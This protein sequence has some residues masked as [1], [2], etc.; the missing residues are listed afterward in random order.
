MKDEREV[1]AA[2]VRE[3]F[4]R[5]EA[6][7]RRRDEV[8]NEALAVRLSLREAV[9]AQAEAAAAYTRAARARH[10]ARVAASE[11]EGEAEGE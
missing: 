8:E 11:A 7:R 10:A 3:A 6:L 5:V 9:V 4:E 2:A 1:T